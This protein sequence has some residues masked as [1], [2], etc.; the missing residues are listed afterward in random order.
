[1]LRCLG[2]TGA[3]FF[4]GQGRQAGRVDEDPA[5]LMKSPDQVFAFGEIHPDFAANA[6]VDLRQNG[7]WHLDEW[8][9]P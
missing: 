4:D 5:R 7:G 8:K 3:A 6:A 9:A 1:M 2:Q